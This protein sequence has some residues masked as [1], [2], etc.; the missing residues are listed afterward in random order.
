M[1]TVPKAKGQGQGQGPQIDPQFLQMAAAY[2]Q[3]QKQTEAL[4]RGPDSDTGKEPTG[5]KSGKS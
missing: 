5:D 2:I 3:Q 4:L 1:L